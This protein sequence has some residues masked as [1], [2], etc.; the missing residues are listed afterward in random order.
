MVRNGRPDPAIF[1]GRTLL[2]PGAALASEMEV[3]ARLQSDGD[4][5]A[6]AA[7]IWSCRRC[8]VVSASDANRQRFAMASRVLGSKGWPV[9]VRQSGGSVVPQGPGMLN[10][11]LV[12]LVPPAERPS[13]RQNFLKLCGL[14][15]AA[16]EGLQVESSNGSLPGSFCDG[17]FNILLSGR[18]FGG[19]AQR[20]IT[21]S[22]NQRMAVI[23]HAV[24]LAEALETDAIEAVGLYRSV[25]G[26][27]EHFDPETCISLKEHV[28]DRSWIAFSGHSAKAALARALIETLV[29][30]EDGELCR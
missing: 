10:C 9:L 12:W 13:I 8:L 30:V 3:A 17:R 26:S 28:A 24:L 7:L 19:T 6:L 11:T 2:N 16:L 1:V 21:G 14:V 25:M 29:G 4:A 22:R 18:K 27:T 15:T 20:W 23:A 5:P